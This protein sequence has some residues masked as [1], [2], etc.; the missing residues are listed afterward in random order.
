MLTW[1]T[2]KH[3][4]NVRKNADLQIGVENRDYHHLSR[5]EIGSDKG[6]SRHLT[7]FPPE[8]RM[9][10]EQPTGNLKLRIAAASLGRLTG[11]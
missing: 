4:F 2:R 11:R 5:F 3:A 1:R 6:I 10:S 7:S 8:S 9:S